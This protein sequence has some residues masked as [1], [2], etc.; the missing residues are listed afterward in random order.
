LSSSAWNASTGDQ[1]VVITVVSDVV[2]PWCFIG[3]RNLDSALRMFSA[4]HPDIRIGVR[5]MP[6]FLNPDTPPQGDP[7]R[8]FLEKKFGGAAA[9]EAIWLRVTKAGRSAD[10]E[11]AFDKIKLRANTFNAHRLIHRFQQRDQ[12]GAIVE[13]LFAANFQRGENINDPAVLARVAVDC[14]D[15]PHEVQRYLSSAEGSSEVLAEVQLAQEAG[16]SGVPFFI[17]NGRQTLSG[18]Q[19]AEV[20]LAMLEQVL[21][22]GD[23]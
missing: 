20:L 18:A 14:G 16:I 9:L 22:A 7:Y 2:C 11:F 15:D 6:F 8:P 4:K 5:W 19:P 13:R 23:E 12:A 3:K 21:I 1:R 17:F 10:I